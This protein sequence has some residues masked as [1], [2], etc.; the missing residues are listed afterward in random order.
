MKTNYMYCQ[1]LEDI[2][3][4]MFVFD[5]AKYDKALENLKTV[6]QNYDT[7]EKNGTISGSAA[8]N[9]LQ[10]SR[11]NMNKWSTL[12]LRFDTELYKNGKR[13]KTVKYRYEKR[14]IP[15][16]LAKQFDNI[17]DIKDK[18]CVSNMY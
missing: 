12:T 2:I 7:I 6:R 17:V 4:C 10:Q 18:V 8:M 15:K 13:N 16:K 9:S 14:K 5:Q 1:L 11:F 3:D